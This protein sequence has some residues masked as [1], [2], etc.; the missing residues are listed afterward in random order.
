MAEKQ[1][2]R[3]G[4]RDPV[5]G[6]RGKPIEYV[7]DEP[8]PEYEQLTDV[9]RESLPAADVER[10]YKPR[11]RHWAPHSGMQV[12]SGTKGGETA[13]EMLQ[14]YLN[15]QRVPQVPDSRK[16]ELTERGEAVDERL[17]E[18]NYERSGSM[19]LGE[20]IVQLMKTGAVK[21]V[22]PKLRQLLAQLEAERGK[23]RKEFDEHAERW[24]AKTA[25]MNSQELLEQEFPELKKEAMKR[26]MDKNEDLLPKDESADLDKE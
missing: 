14:E 16:W 4:V 2:S 12:A 5:T 23:A 11:S 26:I 1:K 15:R 9:Q 20:D 19:Y 7:G 8:L 10:E 3:T 6:K 24:K 13:E 18:L 21:V 17:G 25:A 22:D